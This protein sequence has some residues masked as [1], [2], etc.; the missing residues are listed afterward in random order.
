MSVMAKGNLRLPVREFECMLRIEPMYEQMD[1]QSGIYVCVCVFSLLA[2]N[3]RNCKSSLPS[4]GY[5]G[6]LIMN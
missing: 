5:R 1:E 3:R 6:V 4:G 2:K